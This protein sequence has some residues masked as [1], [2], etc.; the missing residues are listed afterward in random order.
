MGKIISFGSLNIDYVYN[1]NHFVTPGETI[2]SSIHEVF[3]GGKGLN[4]SIALARGGGEVYHVGNIGIDG[5]WLK[6]LLEKNNI[7][8]SMLSVHS[9][10]TGHAIIQ[11]NNKGENC[12]ILYGGANNLVTKEQIELTLESFNSDDIL[13]IQNEINMLDQIIQIAHDKGMQIALNPSPMDKDLLKLP[14]EK[15]TWFLLN[16]VEGFSLTGEKE[17]NK[18]LDAL[19]DLF[20]LAK[21]VLTLGKSGVVY[22][23][24]NQQHFHG[25]YNVNVVD[26]TG[27]GDTF[28]GFFLS[29]ISRGKTVVEALETASIASS[30]AISKKGAAVAI[31]TLE[32]VHRSTLTL[33]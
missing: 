20:P 3:P 7:N 32:E 9:S 11:V 26:T 8:V 22:R 17:P 27:A 25:I 5:V 28:T 30:L 4:Q 24:I 10:P 19:S 14:L 33:A 29:A 21:I 1:V 31:P 15:I 6:E 23:D 18:I 12:I 2:S 13:V 16:E